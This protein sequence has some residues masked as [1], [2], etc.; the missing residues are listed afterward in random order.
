MAM[1]MTSAKIP[2]LLAI[3]LAFAAV[4]APAQLPLD[5]LMQ[6]KFVNPLP[7]PAVLTGTYH[8]I[9]MTQFSQ[10]LGLVDPLTCAPLSTTVWG[11]GG[12]YPGPTI[13][14]VRGVPINVRW[15]N[16]L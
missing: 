7:R 1:R 15:V 5:P 9:E 16:N 12:S 3:L 14:A 6:P 11:Y 8:E 13:E 4:D 2:V 10:Y